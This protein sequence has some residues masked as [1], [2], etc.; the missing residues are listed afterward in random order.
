V[1]ALFRDRGLFVVGSCVRHVNHPFLRVASRM[2][3]HPS[4]LGRTQ[5][6]SSTIMLRNALARTKASAGA[7]LNDWDE[8]AGLMSGMR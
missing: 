4:G 3:I 1:R 8:K 5:V 6:K 7:F 2:T